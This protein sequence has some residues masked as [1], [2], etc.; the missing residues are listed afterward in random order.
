MVVKNIARTVING[1]LSRMVNYWG[2][3]N[4]GVST[5]AIRF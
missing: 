1:L 2:S 4:I 5:A 3:S